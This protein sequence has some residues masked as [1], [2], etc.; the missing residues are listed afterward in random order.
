[1][2][3]IRSMLGSCVDSEDGEI[4]LKPLWTFTE[5]ALCIL[6][7]TLRHQPEPGSTQPSPLT[8]HR[9]WSKLVSFSEPQHPRYQTRLLCLLHWQADSLL[10]RHLENPVKVYMGWYMKSRQPRTQAEHSRCS[11]KNNSYCCCCSQFIQT[12]KLL[13]KQL[14]PQSKLMGVAEAPAQ[15]P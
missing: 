6:Q 14:I 11:I 15:T 8:N 2:S 9:T 10:L 3:P 5:L 7:Y 13:H 1:M 4:N 12:A